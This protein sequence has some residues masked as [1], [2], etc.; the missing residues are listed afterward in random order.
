MELSRMEAPYPPT[1]VSTRA[2]RRFRV[3]LPAV[4][5]EG[6][7]VHAG[8][9][10]LLRLAWMRGARNVVFGAAGGHGPLELGAMAAVLGGWHVDPSHIWRGVGGVS[11]GTL[12]ALALMTGT[13]MAR[14]AAI[15]A[16]F[17]FGG[18]FSNDVVSVLADRGLAGVL[19][20]GG[21]GGGGGGRAGF[22]R[23]PSGAKGGAG[24]PSAAKGSTPARATPARATPTPTPESTP[25]SSAVEGWLQQLSG[26]NGFLEG[27]SL[28]TV[29]YT[30][31]VEMGIPL[32]ITFEEALARYR[33]DLRIAV[34][35][36]VSQRLCVCS[37]GTTPRAKV[38][39][40]VVASM[41]IPLMFRPQPIRGV[42]SQSGG[43]SP[44]LYPPC[45]APIRPEIT[46]RFSDGGVADP[47][48]LQLFPGDA[49]TTLH[50]CKVTNMGA[51]RN[52]DSFASV[53]TSAVACAS[54]IADMYANESTATPRG[55]RRVNMLGTMAGARD[56]KDERDVAGGSMDLF[57]NPPIRPLLR[58]GAEGVD[59]TIT[60]CWITLV[61]AAAAVAARRR[62]RGAKS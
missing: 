46:H 21:G 40:A 52:V 37:A 45:P 15:N 55:F 26:V 13:P 23:P 10:R 11:I 1:T 30:A 19:G 7:D 44:H 17:P 2:R 6:G 16:R 59:A 54:G 24:T 14:L 43:E 33:T 29:A 22:G 56:A 35:D 18:T 28:R 50:V 12:L 9:T 25:S 49:D 57:S 34:S 20:V 32:E 58:D 4:S 8:V 38:L 31:F 3:A 36:L 62:G 60:L 53:F 5:E 61:A 42:F 51:S 41:A 47:F 48:G 27:N 39:D